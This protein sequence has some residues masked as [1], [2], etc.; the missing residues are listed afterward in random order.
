MLM[1][2]GFPID[3]REPNG[4]WPLR[5]CPGDFAAT[6]VRIGRVACEEHYGTRRKT[7]DRWL[8]EFGKARLI[9]LRAA[10]V[11]NRIEDA[12]RLRVLADVASILKQ[13]IPVLDKRVVSFT[14]AR[15][16]AQFLRSI[17][18]GGWIVSPA[19]DGDWWV[20]SRR[21]SAAELVDLATAKGFDA[22]LTGDDR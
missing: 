8:G 21:R 2:A 6:F 16:A 15:H 5:A 20:G 12:R 13:S 4:R 1:T 9:E 11:R 7:V 17:R 10:F 18:N 14:L 3:E 22:S 19:P